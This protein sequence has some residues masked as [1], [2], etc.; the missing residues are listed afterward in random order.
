MPIDL[1]VIGSHPDDVEL[2]CAGT[3][4]KLVRQ[5]RQVVI[6]DLTEGE[7]GTRGTREIRSKEAKEAAEVLGVSERRNLGIP[8]ADIQCNRENISAL[9]ALIRELRPKLLLIPYSHDRH[10]DHVHTHQLCK[11]A[12]FYSGLKKFQLVGQ[13]AGSQEFRPD[14]CFEYMQWFE[15]QPSFIVDVSDTFE[16]K[17]K[18][19]AAYK[20]Q[21]H[22]PSSTEPET[23]L[24]R[25]HFLMMTETRSRHYGQKIGVEHGEPFYFEGS[26]GIGSFFDLKIDRG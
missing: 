8:D 10:P 3:V 24:S 9:A 6:A 1:L 11:E 25:P 16:V 15:F 2:T 7:M 21:F 17:L 18:A 13:P 23:K 5:G 12:W 20:S 19:I 4:A 14:G 22:N 26:L